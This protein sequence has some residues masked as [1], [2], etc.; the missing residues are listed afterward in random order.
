MQLV[1]CILGFRSL[2]HKSLKT[3]N[4][5]CKTEGGKGKKGKLKPSLNVRCYPGSTGVV[6]GYFTCGFL[7]SIT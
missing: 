6:V 4:A 7:F 2:S 3:E 1:L 5:V